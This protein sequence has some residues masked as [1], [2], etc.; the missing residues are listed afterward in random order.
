MTEVLYNLSA[1][2]GEV[3]AKGHVMFFPPWASIASNAEA[4]AAAVCEEH[5]NEETWAEFFF[6]SSRECLLV[7]I[8]SPETVAGKFCVDVALKPKATAR[9]VPNEQSA[10]QGKT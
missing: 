6:D 8:L 10:T 2:S 4:V 1:E 3:L 7:E 9:R 5:L